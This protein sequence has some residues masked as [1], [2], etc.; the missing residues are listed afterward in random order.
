MKFLKYIALVFIL[1]LFSCK[2]ENKEKGAE[3]ESENLTEQITK[4]V[5]VD[6]QVNSLSMILSSKSGSEV[7]GTVTFTDNNGKISMEASLMGLSE[8]EHAIHIH[9]KADCTSDDGK[10]SGGHWNPTFAPHGKWGD[11][12]GY[13]RGD[14]GNFTVKA[15]GLAVVKFD[16]GDSWCLG[17]DDETKNIVGKAIVVHQG[18]DDYTSQPSGAAGARVSCGGIIE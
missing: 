15:D 9:E 16:A 2:N 10:S 7:T 3:T 13:H 12:A 4:E 6:E 5:I 11:E 8:G 1:I 18:V 14:I 17:C